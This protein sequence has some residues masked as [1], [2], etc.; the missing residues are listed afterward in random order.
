MALP[1]IEALDALIEQQQS[2]LTDPAERDRALADIE[3]ELEGML[4]N[5]STYRG[6]AQV[7]M[8]GRSG[9][10]SGPKE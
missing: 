7:Q 8:R 10:G 4:S 5:V 2:T 1:Q 6:D 9:N 3:F